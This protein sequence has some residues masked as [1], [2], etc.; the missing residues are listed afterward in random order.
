MNVSIKYLNLQKFVLAG[1][2][3]SEEVK[4]KVAQSCLTLCDPWP[5]QSIQFPG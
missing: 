1:M 5:I 2:F 4:A 3:T